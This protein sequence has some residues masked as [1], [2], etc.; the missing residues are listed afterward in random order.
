MSFLLALFP[1][2][3]RSLFFLCCSID[4]GFGGFIATPDNTAELVAQLRA[5]FGDM[6]PAFATACLKA[7]GWVVNSV[8]DRVLDGKLS[9]ELLALREQQDKH[10]AEAAAGAVG[11]PALERKQSDG[12]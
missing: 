1:N 5:I 8:V 10:T 3:P 12:N 9:P 4:V 11:L 7:Y 2:V 6:T